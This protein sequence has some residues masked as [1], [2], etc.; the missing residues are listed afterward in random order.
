M[1]QRCWGY[2][3]EQGGLRVRVEEERGGKEIDGY[4]LTTIPFIITFI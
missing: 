1:V 2:T 4:P 3:Y